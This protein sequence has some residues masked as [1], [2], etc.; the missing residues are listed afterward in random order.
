METIN[1]EISPNEVAR[2]AQ[3]AF[4]LEPIANKPGLTTRYSNKNKNLKLENF[5]T[6]GINIG[7][8]F[9]ELA[10]RIIMKLH[11]IFKN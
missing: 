1:K 6:A 2:I 8:A 11:Y 7:D 9:R 3:L 10:I 5:I 4:V